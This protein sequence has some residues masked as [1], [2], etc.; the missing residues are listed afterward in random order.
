[1]TPEAHQAL[2]KVEQAITNAQLERCGDSQPV[3]MCPFNLISTRALTA[4]DSTTQAQEFH[5]LYHV[6]STVLRKKFNI[7]RALARNIV[8][9]CYPKDWG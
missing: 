1:M 7:T 5:K 2:Q 8:K 9:S 6:S 4:L 3:W